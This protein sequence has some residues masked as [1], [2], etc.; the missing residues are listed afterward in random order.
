MNIEKRKPGFEYRDNFQINDDEYTTLEKCLLN[1]FQRDFPLSR[2]P[3]AEIAKKLD[4]D[5]A[6]VISAIEKL[7]NSGS[8][9][10]IGPIVKPNTLNTSML[11]AMSV[12]ED[13]LHEIA[14]YINSYNEVNHNYEREHYFNLWFV[15]HGQDEQHVH[16]LLDKIEE[17]TEYTLLRLPIL[18]DYH[19]DLGF[20]LKWT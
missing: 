11:A 18:D 17:E 7:Q 4:T 2:D 14:E 12:P 5:K 13:Q 1:D 9:S 6:T 15:I 16:F 20:D 10:R 8:I 19:I 3:Y